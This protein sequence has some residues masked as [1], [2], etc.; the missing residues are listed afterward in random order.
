ME[1]IL[2]TTSDG[3]KISCGVILVDG[4]GTILAGHPTGRAY[5]HGCYDLFKGCAREGEEDLDC[6]IREMKEESGIDIRKYREQIIDVGIHKYNREK[7]LHLYVLKMEELPSLLQVW[8]DS[9][10]TDKQGRTYP[11]MNAYRRIGK[12]ERHCFFRGI[13]NALNNIKEIN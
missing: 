4:D 13:Q 8:C 9:T 2:K 11:E 5:T 6:A 12:D 10:F 7:V 3:K 1:E